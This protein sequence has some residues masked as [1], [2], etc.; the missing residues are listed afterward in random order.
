V[1][2]IRESAEKLPHKPKISVVTP[3]FNPPIV[4]FRACLDSVL[5]QGYQNW[6][7]CLSDDCSTDP[8]VKEI[9]KEYCHKDP[10]VKAV[11]RESSGHISAATNSALGISTGEY[12]AFLDH[13]DELTPDALYLVAREVNHYPQAQLIY[14]DEDK[15]TPDG[16]RVDPHFKSDWNPELLTQLNYICHLLVIKRSAL[17]SVDG[18]RTQCDGAQDWDLILR[19]SEKLS[20]REIRHIPHVLYHWI[21][22]PGSTAQ[23]TSA[24]PYVLEAQRRVVEA[25]L[26]RTGQLAHVSISHGLSHLRID[27]RVIGVAPKVSLLI[28]TRD[29]LSFL[30][31]CVDSLLERTKYTNFE[32]VIVD[33]GSKEPETL[34]YFREIQRGHANVRVHRDDRPFNFS[35]LNNFGVEHCSGEVFGFLNNDLKFTNGEWLERM[36]AQVVREE[37]GVVGARLLFP[38]NL[39]QH[40]GIILG[41]DGVAGHNHK[42]LVR[43]D[44]GYFNRAILSQNVS[45]VTAACM[46]VRRDVFNLVGGFDDKL[47]VAF[48]DVDFCLR[49]RAAGFRVVYE[50]RAEAFHY[51]SATRGYETTPERL[52]RFERERS[53]MKARWGRNLDFD[54]YYNPN[55]SLMTE[56]F[57][58]SFPPRMARPWRNG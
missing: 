53:L 48:N 35:A 57:S 21:V 52:S 26:Q 44:P 43:E 20:E 46:L 30:K 40:G 2:R 14:S 16:N 25:H 36:V 23:S 18:L 13:D 28:L 47:S 15:K 55:L 42:G 11:F 10:R 3:V 56:D 17:E 4:K 22:I 39:L 1:D 37:V 5:T 49:I 12:V 32:V 19:V 8:L 33:N 31:P 29:K 6:E 24:K 45:A 54:P 51:E 41:I 27:R 34:E 7:L 50:A 9:I 38:N 58:L